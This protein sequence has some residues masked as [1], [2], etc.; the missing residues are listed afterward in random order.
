MLSMDDGDS[1]DA[2]SYFDAAELSTTEPPAVSA[3]LTGAESVRWRNHQPSIVPIAPLDREVKF[4]VTPLVRRRG[5][6]SPRMP[7]ATSYV[8]DC[9][10]TGAISANVGANCRGG[11]HFWCVRPAWRIRHRC[12]RVEGVV[13]APKSK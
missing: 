1:S 3:P 2:M 5:G 9:D 11:R 4:H 10:V 6:Q 13:I 7:A 12:K 8:V